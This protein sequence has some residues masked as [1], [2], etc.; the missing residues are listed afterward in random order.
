MTISCFLAPSPP[1]LPG[2][3][4]CYCYL[5]TFSSKLHDHERNWINL[6]VHIPGTPAG[7]ANDDHHQ[8]LDKHFSHCEV[9]KVSSVFKWMEVLNRQ[10]K[11]IAFSQST[12][13]LAAHCGFFGITSVMLLLYSRRQG[14]KDSYPLSIIAFIFH[15]V[16][17]GGGPGAIWSNNR[18]QS[19]V[20]RLMH[21]PPVWEILD[22][23]LNVYVSFIFDQ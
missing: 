17:W 3:L 6:E 14:F 21:P 2:S 1:T 23:P 15:A 7:S 8:F 16:F 22:P 13:L 10:V 11:L 9:L 12:R 19:P 4:I 18:L 20:L 5:A